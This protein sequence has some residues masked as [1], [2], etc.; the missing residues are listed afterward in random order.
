MPTE[1]PAPLEGIAIIGMAGRFPGAPD[2]ES[3][4]K[5]LTEGRETITTFDRSALPAEE[6]SH[7]ADYVPRRGVLDRPEWFDA[8]FFNIAPREAETM[9]PQQRIFLETCWH[10]LENGG[11]DPEQFHGSIGVFAGMSNNSWLQ[12]RVLLNKEL[13][14]QVGYEAAMICNEKDYL[15]TRTAYKLNL[16]GPALNIYTACSTSLV[17]VCQAVQALQSFQ[18]DAALAGGVSVKWPQERGFTAQEGSIYSPDGHC[19]PYDAAATGTV[20]S[21]GIGVLLLK[22]HEDAVRI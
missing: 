11:C 1:S 20:F 15:A 5:V 21:N 9:D 4:W 19:R 17:A 3:F 18:C 13:R 22:R 2:I 8:A 7:D 6:P 12:H 14:A 16:R 10:A